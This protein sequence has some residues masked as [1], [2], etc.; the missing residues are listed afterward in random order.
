MKLIEVVQK[1]KYY[2][3]HLFFIYTKK[4]VAELLGKSEKS[5]KS[6]ASAPK[7]A[8]TAKKVVA[9]LKPSIPSVPTV[10]DRWIEYCDKNKIRYGKNNLKYW[11]KKLNQR[12]G[13]DQQE[14]IYI[15]IKRGWKDFYIVP[16]K[17]SKYHR[18]LGKSLMM[19]RDCD[20]LLDIGYVNKRYIYHF[21]N[22]KITTTAPPLELFKNYGYDRS[23]VKKAPIV[24]VVQERIFGLI[25][26][27]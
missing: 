12:L 26:R 9:R 23:E 4:K 16:I 5:Q 19:E 1:R 24:S 21:K 17:A 14:A 8:E 11:E 22:I 27:F 10:F 2:Y 3:V 25:K 15:A 20:T 13:I 18:L 7:K 6:T